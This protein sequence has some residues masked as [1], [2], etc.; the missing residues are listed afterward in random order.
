MCKDPYFIEKLGKV[1][2]KEVAGV[3]ILVI[4]I[5]KETGAK[6]V[7]SSIQL[8]T[9]LQRYLNK[10][11]KEYGKFLPFLSKEG[12]E[13]FSLEVMPI[14]SSMILKPEIILEQYYL[15]DPSFNLNTSR[16][17]NVP[18]FKSKELFMYNKDKT[19]LI[20]HSSSIKNFHVKFG[21]SHTAITAFFETGSYYLGKYVFSSVPIL[22]AEAGNYSEKEIRAMIDNG[23]LDK[24]LYMYNE[25][26]SI[27]YFS[28]LKSDFAQLGIH[29]WNLNVSSH[30]D[31]DSLYLGKYILTTTKILP[32][33][34]SDMSVT[35]I[36]AML[37]KDKESLNIISGKAKRVVLLDVKTNQTFSRV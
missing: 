3:Y 9:R 34:P 23:R 36:T 22:T 35:E 28:G 7:G 18:G 19:I 24:I 15:L 20:Y 33:S 17:A 21:I 12:I 29:V 14:Y 30:I 31:T 37:N 25:D 5:V 4:H 10:T 8:A 2:G 6:Y 1:K 16:V 32:T 13:K 27:L 26:K 11:Y